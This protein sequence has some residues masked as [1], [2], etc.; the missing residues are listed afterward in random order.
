MAERKNPATATKQDL[1]D[2]REDVGVLKTDVKALTQQVNALD[3]TT[4][5]LVIRVLGMEERMAT[6]EEMDKRFNQVSNQI[7]GL[8][9]LIKDSERDEAFTWGPKYIVLTEKVDGHEE[10]IVKLEATLQK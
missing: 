9:N 6:K 2:I 1:Q 7:D 4:K 3:Q 10:R 5:N 8:A